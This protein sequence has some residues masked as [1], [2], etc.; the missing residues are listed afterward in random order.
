MPLFPYR[1]SRFNKNAYCI[2]KSAVQ[3]K[4]TNTKGITQCKDKETITIDKDTYSSMRISPRKLSVFSVYLTWAAGPTLH[5]DIEIDETGEWSDETQGLWG[6]SA[7]GDSGQGEDA[8]SLVWGSSGV[9]LVP[10][11][12]RVR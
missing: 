6:Q 1:L 8:R 7:G 5:T 9:V 12:P 3:S 10:K 11:E 4:E 2:H